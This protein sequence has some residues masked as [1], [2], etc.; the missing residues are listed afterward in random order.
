MN[1][2]KH[3]FVLLFS[4]ASLFAAAGVTKAVHIPRN[5]DEVDMQRCEVL[6]P[7]SSGVDAVWDF[8][9]AVPVGESHRVKYLSF[10]DSLLVRTENATMHTFL[11]KGDSVLWKG[12]ENRLSALTDSIAPLQMLL[13]MEYGDSITTPLYMVGNYCAHNALT[14]LGYHTVHIDGKGILILPS[15]TVKNVVRMH[16]LTTAK[17]KVAKDN[18]RQSLTA[19]SDSLIDKVEEKYL[20]FS[21]NYRFPLAEVRLSTIGVGT[22]EESCSAVSYI[23]P[24]AVQDYALGTN[25]SPLANSPSADSNTGNEENGNEVTIIQNLELN[26]GNGFVDVSFIP[27]ASGMV[28]LVLTDVY[29]RVFASIPKKAAQSGVAYSDRVD[30]SRLPSGS[31]V[32]Y[33]NVA[34]ETQNRKFT[35]K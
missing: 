10:G 13:P 12:C 1:Y 32:L 35:I 4:L 25:F 26:T 22:P 9:E 31:Y 3:K 18:R 24:P 6:N 29:G 30:V 11:I 33:V 23:C 14:M 34:N 19:D 15:E 5:G 28:S 21:D 2:L 8:S 20:W 27:G 16:V 7:G 17:V